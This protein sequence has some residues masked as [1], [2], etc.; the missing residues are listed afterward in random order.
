MAIDER[1]RGRLPPRKLDGKAQAEARSRHAQLVLAHFFKDASAIDI[2]RA[3]CLPMKGGCLLGHSKYSRDAGGRVRDDV[4]ETA[5]ASEVDADRVPIRVESDVV[6]R[7]DGEKALRGLL[8]G[9]GVGNVEL[10]SCAGGERRGKR[11]GGFVELA[12]VINV[13]V[14]RGY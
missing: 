10:E 14:K 1:N 12:G 9:T 3:G 7:A 13:R 11:N 4:T 6:G 5:K 8:D 2:S